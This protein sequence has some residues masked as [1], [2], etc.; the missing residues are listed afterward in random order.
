MPRWMQPT[1]TRRRET[2]VPA[3]S[4]AGM[5]HQALLLSM[6]IALPAI[7]VAALMGLLLASVQAASQ[8]QDGALSHVP[9]IVVVSVVLAFTGTWMGHHVVAFALRA[10]GG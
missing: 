2:D 3:T 7:S 8:V 9:R 5:V 4:L 1:L 10:F 6:V